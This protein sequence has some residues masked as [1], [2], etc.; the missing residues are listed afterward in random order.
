LHRI[1]TRDFIK[2]VGLWAGNENIVCIKI[3]ETDLSAKNMAGSLVKR[4]LSNKSHF[5]PLP[6]INELRRNVGESNQLSIILRAKSNTNELLT[7]LLE[8]SA[9]NDLLALKRLQV[10]NNAD[11]RAL[12]ALSHRKIFLIARHSHRSY[13]F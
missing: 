13:S 9:C 7:F 6:N 4:L 2:L 10:V 3:A 8:L 12:S 5:V 1:V 11:R